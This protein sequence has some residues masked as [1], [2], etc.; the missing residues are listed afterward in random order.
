MGPGETTHPV[1]C[2][3]FNLGESNEIL[4]YQQSLATPLQTVEASDGVEGKWKMWFD[5]LV[6]A[7]NTALP[8]VTTKPEDD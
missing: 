5:A 1:T 8:L 3:C 2:V 7:Q 6:T 4:S